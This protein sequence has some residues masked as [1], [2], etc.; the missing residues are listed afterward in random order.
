MN[1]IKLELERR[2][3]EAAKIE[4]NDVAL[5]IATSIT[6]MILHYL[7]HE[8]LICAIDHEVY[9]RL[10]KRL[11]LYLF[12]LTSEVDETKRNAN[13]EECR[14]RAI[15]KVTDEQRALSVVDP[16]WRKVD[17]NGIPV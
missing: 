15:A 4:D 16:N 11:G 7:P 13:I 17:S 2:I 8:D 1:P 5:C 12:E 6:D 9:A 10:N 14:Q 3:V